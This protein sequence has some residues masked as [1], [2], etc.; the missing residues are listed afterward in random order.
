MG[1]DRSR[2]LALRV[3]TLWQG[4]IAL[5]LEEG[6]AD[7]S[8][9][10]RLL[11]G[12]LERRQLGRNV[13]PFRKLETDGPF[14]IACSRPQDIDCE[15]GLLEDVHPI[16]AVDII[17]ADFESRRSRHDLTLAGKDLLH[18]VQFLLCLSGRGHCERVLVLVGEVPRLVRAQVGQ[19]LGDGGGF[20]SRG[21][22]IGE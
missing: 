1:T 2:P 17:D 5:D 13:H 6:S 20:E 10:L 16:D 15:P 8:G 11:T 7:L 3:V 4:M 12:E 9:E 14:A 19:R 21:G 22:D 18:P